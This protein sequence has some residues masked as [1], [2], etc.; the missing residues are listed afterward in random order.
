MSKIS[1]GLAMASM[2]SL[3]VVQGAISAPN[4]NNWHHLGEE[5]NGIS[6]YLNRTPFRDPEEGDRIY[7]N[8]LVSNVKGSVLLYIT[9]TCTTPSAR[10]LQVVYFDANG[11]LLGNTN[12]ASMDALQRQNIETVTPGS[13]GLGLLQHAC[14]LSNR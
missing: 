7:Y 13:N 2:G 5:E 14:Q 8:F 3:I 9:G 10:I 6:F 11:Q 4:I 1:L 12:P